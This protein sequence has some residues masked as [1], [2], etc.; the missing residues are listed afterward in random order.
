MLSFTS[1]YQEGAHASIVNALVRSN[2]EQTA[3]YGLDEYT[4]SAKARIRRAA[5]CP[6][7][8]VFLL[9]GGTQ[10][11]SIVI[12]SILKCYQGVL[13]ADTG[14]VSLHEAGAI[15][16]GG[17]K[18]LTVPS[19]D[20][21]IKA[22]QIARAWKD[23]TE[24]D[25]RDHMV[26]PGLV[27]ISQPTEAGTLYSLKE[28]TEISETCRS[29]GLPLYVDGARLAYALASPENDVTLPDLA[30]LCDAF[31][32]G[33]T[34]CGALF[35]E[36]VVLPDPSLIPHFFT[37]IKQK[38]ALLAKGRLLGIQFA[39]LFRDDLYLTIGSDAIRYARR[40]EQA[41]SESGYPL[42]PATP[43]NQVFAV[44]TK[45]KMNEL[46]QYAAF[47]FWAFL[48]ETHIVVR[49]ATSW[50]TTEEDTNELVRILKAHP[51]N[52]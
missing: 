49:F 31:Y 21:K 14:H 47:E 26:M 46:L 13:A 15:E 5:D 44:M 16:A 20:G 36:A 35:G 8:A 4:A 23:F 32:I 39:E 17:H 50:A 6:D 51:A 9:V 27:Y 12:G 43:T 34:K 7:A 41:L 48:D 37:I 29:V 25:N 1:D 38:G 40:I 18:V 3:G 30:R 2:L 19:A 45:E 10:T 28:L 22:A 24:D 33:G 42:A 52:A 11:N